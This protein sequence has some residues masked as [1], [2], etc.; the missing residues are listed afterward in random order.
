MSSPV[1]FVASGGKYS[2]RS[3]AH[4]GRRPHGDDPTVSTTTPSLEQYWACML[5]HDCAVTTSALSIPHRSVASLHE[6]SGRSMSTP[7]SDRRAQ[8]GQPSFVASICKHFFQT[9]VNN[10]E[11]SRRAGFP[12]FASRTL[13]FLLYQSKNKSVRFKVVGTAAIASAYSVKQTEKCLRDIA[14]HFSK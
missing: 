10:T 13:L 4:R 12:H 8:R 6:R 5:S 3:N 1:R 14:D 7:P 11:F 2:S 9:P